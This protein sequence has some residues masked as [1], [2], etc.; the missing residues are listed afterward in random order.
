MTYSRPTNLEEALAIRADRQAQV[1]AGATDI[2]PMKATQEA[3]GQ[4][5]PSDMLDISAVDA[6][7]GIDDIGD[8]WRIG[9]LVTW[10][11]I[12]DADLPAAFDGLK[13][14]AVE[15]GGQ[16]I[17]NRGTL[18]GNLCNASP[19]ADGVPP[20]LALDAEI[21]LQN[22]D[23]ER[24]IALSEFIDDYRHTLLQG[25]EIVTA[26][27]VPK[28]PD[29]AQSHFLKLGARRYL[30][31]SIAMASVVVV[32]DKTGKIADVRIALGSCSPVAQRL[33]RLEQ[34]LVGRS[35]DRALGNVPK[36]AHLEALAP[37]DD[38][39]ATSTYRRNAALNLLC[40][41]LAQIG[42]A[43]RRRIV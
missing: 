15:I 10:R 19:A 33:P 41:L 17:Q 6:L 9:A 35:L 38:I 26:I 40:E 43:E 1:I 39:R 34:E 14:A 8:G 22:K 37:I 18:A 36:P 42:T 4:Y 21:E 31:I 29:A 12:I 7:R 2:Y 3:W 24:R 28:L 16:Q 32:P 13:L 23:G 27:F 11:D 20:L 30:I 25:D 5:E